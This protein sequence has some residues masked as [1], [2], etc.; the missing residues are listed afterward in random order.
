PEEDSPPVSPVKIRSLRALI[1]EKMRVGDRASVRALTEKFRSEYA[2]FSRGK[3]PEQVEQALSKAE[4]LA[5]I[6]DQ[7]ERARDSARAATSLEAVTRKLIEDLFD[8]WDAG[9]ITNRQIRHRLER[10]VRASY[11]ASGAIA[12][13]HTRRAADLPD[14]APADDTFSTEYLS[15]LLTDVRRNLREYGAVNRRAS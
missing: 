15:S 12:R 6:A 8:D 7:L 11:R 3:T 13:E 10:A 1:L 5:S 4:Q 2:R 14:W 9:R